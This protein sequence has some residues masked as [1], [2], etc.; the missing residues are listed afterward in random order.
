[1]GARDGVSY[2]QSKMRMTPM[3]KKIRRK[4]RITENEEIPTENEVEELQL[5]DLR[6]QFEESFDS[7]SDFDDDITKKY[8]S[9]EQSECDLESW[10]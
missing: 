7:E 6:R 8:L 2:D 9:A 10:L 4:D 1:M 5:Q 3:K